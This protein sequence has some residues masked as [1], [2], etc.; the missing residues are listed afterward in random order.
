MVVIGI[1]GHGGFADGLMS[2]ARL[3][4]GQQE[5]IFALGLR[6]DESPEGYGQ[7]LHEELA[8]YEGC[9]FLFLIDLK[10][11]TPF[12]VAARLSD[13]RHY[14]VTGANLPMLLKVLMERD[15]M[16]ELEALVASTVSDGK[17][18]IVDLTAEIKNMKA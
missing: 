2:A 18:S 13:S 15:T 11:G 17:E 1:L 12:N 7:R 14:C 6:P 4:C 16:Q 9:E 10:G 5:G 8:R 3:I